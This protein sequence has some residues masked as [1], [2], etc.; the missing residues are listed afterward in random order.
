M[1]LPTSPVQ[2]TPGGDGEEEPLTDEQFETVRARIAAQGRQRPYAEAA[3]SPDPVAAFVRGHM[4]WA[5]LGALNST[6]A[7]F[8]DE[9]SAFVAAA[10]GA[11]VYQPRD[12]GAVLGDLGDL[13]AMFSRYRVG[14]PGQLVAI[15]APVVASLVAAAEQRGAERALCLQSGGPGPHGGEYRCALRK[16]HPAPRGTGHHFEVWQ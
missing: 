4:V 12:G 1:T 2:P 7:A 14:D 3:V 11:P 5:G 9:V 13:R 8:A 16:G 15:A 6:I 10:L